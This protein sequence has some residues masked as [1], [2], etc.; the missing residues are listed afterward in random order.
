MVFS[1]LKFEIYFKV[2]CH[3]VKNKVLH[4]LNG[5]FMKSEDNKETHTFLK[6]DHDRPFFP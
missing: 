4:A 6:L 5:H 1:F 3:S 2:G